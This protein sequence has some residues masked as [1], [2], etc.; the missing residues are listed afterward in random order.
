MAQIPLISS[1]TCFFA[2]FSSLFIISVALAA[3]TPT[4]EGKWKCGEE[5]K[6]EVDEI[7]AR[8]MTFGRPD[9]KFP[10]TKSQF[11]PYCK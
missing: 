4:F 3:P 1:F 10:I 9:R 7:V 2:C 11:K 5:A 8:I 6:K